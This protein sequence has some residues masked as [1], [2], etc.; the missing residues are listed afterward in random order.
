MSDILQCTGRGL[1]TTATG[2]FSDGSGASPYANNSDC[3]WIIAP[4]RGSTSIV[5]IF[6]SFETM[7]DSDFVRV[8]TCTDSSCSVTGLLAEL[9]GN[10]SDIGPESYTSTTGYMLVSF[11]SGDGVHQHD[12]F[13]ASWTSE[14]IPP[15]SMLVA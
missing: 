9:S 3:S 13:T 4:A 5:I 8:Y 6:T 14:F 10:S 15:V 2:S 7:R 12:G 1:L 11:T